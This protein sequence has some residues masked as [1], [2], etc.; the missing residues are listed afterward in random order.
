[1]QLR[2][3]GPDDRDAHAAF[4]AG[5][6]AVFQRAD[7]ARWI[8][9]GEWSDDYLA[10]A[11][12]DG[13]R[14][15]ANA[16]LTRMR[17]RVEGGDVDGWQIGA[18]FCLPEARG[19]GWARRVLD[20]ALDHC[21]DAPVLLFANPSVREFYPRFG[22]APRDEHEF[23]AD[24]ACDPAGEVA[25]TLDVAD[26]AVRARLHA[27]ADACLPESERFGVR[28]QGRIVSW[29]YANGF[30]RPL[31]ALDEDT[32][33]VCGVRDGL[34]HV[35]AILARADFDLRAA[36]PRLIE[37][38][39]RGVRLGF[40]PDRWWPDA[41]AIGVDPEPDLFVRGFDPLPRMPHKFPLLAQT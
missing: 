24:F 16:S 26:P 35:D 36:I 33:L 32:W 11:L 22:F 40:T 27:L 29:Y 41:R 5:V 13:E 30:A 18:V 21:G 7:F 39:I 9:W 3:L 14:V 20:A 1:M 10:C 19:R 12:F 8:D 15:V 23:V 17:L 31:R 28:G 38:P 6:R 34:L 25:P 37:R 4:C 2:R